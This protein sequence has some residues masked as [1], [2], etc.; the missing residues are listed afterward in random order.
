VDIAHI[1]KSIDEQT[2]VLAPVIP[3]KDFIE[4]TK[5]H[6]AATGGAHKKKWPFDG[7]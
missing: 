2:A 6:S 1:S 7:K 3:G 4:A 5:I